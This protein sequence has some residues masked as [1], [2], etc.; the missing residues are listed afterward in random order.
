MK[1]PPPPDA[2]LRVRLVDDHAIVREGYRRLLETEADLRVVGEHPQAE[3]VL[4]ALEQSGGDDTD[5]I[6]LDLSMPGRSGLELLRQLATSWPWLR[7]LVFTMHDSA[8][9]AE[10]ALRA[11]AAGFVTKNCEPSFLLQALRRVAAG[12]Q[13]VLSPDVAAPSP[14][15]RAPPALAPREFEVMQLLL[16]GLPTDEIGRRLGLSSKTVAN[17]QAMIRAKLG[18]GSSIELLHYAQRHGLGPT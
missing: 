13:G 15:P 5:V 4:R 11:G 1:L 2:P 16:E 18:V 14:A 3:S 17:Y 7:V 9:M 12:E 8:A 10:Q 6:V